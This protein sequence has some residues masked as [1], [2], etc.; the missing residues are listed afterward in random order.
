MKLEKIIEN[1]FFPVNI[2]MIAAVTLILYLINSSYSVN[3]LMIFLVSLSVFLFVFRFSKKVK[4]ETKKYSYASS[5]A[6]IVFIILLYFFQVSKEFLF[7]GLTVFFSN[8]I[9]HFIR[10][11]WKISAHVLTYTIFCTTLSIINTNF[12]FLF[13][14]LPF[15]IWSRLKLKRHNM[16]QIFTA[17]VLGIIIPFFI[18]NVLNLF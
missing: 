2:T 6:L 5:L 14:F 11:T 12:I 7:G 16:L 3:H 13:V 15:V 9:I 8:F 1:V 4:S 10:D 17:L 18:E